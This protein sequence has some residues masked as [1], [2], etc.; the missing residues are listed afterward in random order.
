M[1]QFEKITNLLE[2]VI[3][4]MTE[5]YKPEIYSTDV[6]VINKPM[7]DIPAGHILN[8]NWDNIY[9]SFKL[10]T[11]FNLEMAKEI[12]TLAE[13]CPYGVGDI[14]F[15]SSNSN[16]NTRWP[17]TTWKKITEG[18][19]HPVVDND[20]LFKTINKIGGKYE[21][22]LLLKH[23][24]EHDHEVGGFTDTRWGFSPSVQAW[25]EQFKSGKG[26]MLW[27]LK[28]NKIGGNE[29]F[30]ITPKYITKYIW[31]RVS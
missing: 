18:F 26:G 31:E 21:A 16:P 6:N 13:Q 3:S 30:S 15:T 29:P 4:Q 22:S 17:K 23:L 28:T 2:N 14:L 1:E 9:N 12:K 25:G 20:N 27:R 8:I 11:Q 7:A 10:L 5:V 24:P 19:I